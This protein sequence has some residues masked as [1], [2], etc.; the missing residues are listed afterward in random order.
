MPAITPVNPRIQVNGTEISHEAMNS[1]TEV[2]VE[3]EMRLPGRVTLRFR[4]PEGK[5]AKSS[6]FQ[7]GH[8]L[9]VKGANGSHTV[10]IIEA[11]ITGLGFEATAGSDAKDRFDGRRGTSNEFLVIAHDPS[12]RLTRNYTVKGNQQV[13]PGDIVQTLGSEAGLTVQQ[14]LTG[15][16][17]M[18]VMSQLHSDYDL[19]NAIADREGVDWWVENRTLHMGK[20]STT[21]TETLKLGE[22]LRSFSVKGSGLAPSK[23]SVRGYLSDQKQDVVKTSTLTDSTLWPKDVAVLSGLPTKKFGTATLVNAHATPTS[24]TES[25]TIANGI[26][27]RIAAGST[28]AHGE[29]WCN[30]GIAIGKSVKIDGA[31]PADGTY[32]VTKVEHHASRNGFFTRF[33]CGDRT[34]TSLVDSL[35]ARPAPS[36]PARHLGLVIGIVTNL[37]TGEHAGMLRVKLPGLDANLVSAWGR[38][39][40]PSAGPNGRGLVMLPE[41]GDE[42]LVGFEEGDMHRPVIL[43]GLYGPSADKSHA[44]PVTGNNITDRRYTSLNG[45]VVMIQDGKGDPN[46]MFKVTI[47]GD[48]GSIVLRMGGDKA[49]VTTPDDVPIEI[50]SGSQ[51]SIKMDG[52]GNIT[53]KGIKISIEAEAE[54][55][56]KAPKVGV[57]ADGELQLKSEGKADLQGAMVNVTAQG[58]L[59]AKGAIVQIN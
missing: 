55:S 19:L 52:K 14:S 59:A 40:A 56:I 18:T 34:P 4:D 12:F 51:S 25:E 32:H 43:G 9:T 15:G 16:S 39:V 37:G 3:T 50:S 13:T 46:N 28:R 38:F 8:T 49:E 44:W 17:P 30:P 21:S 53:I 2:R 36:L 27:D 20:A 35:A 26:R 47:K 5:L 1:L 31:G 58:P 24:S 22:D 41:I 45:H 11:D 57:A 7:I 29:T 48:K 6:T 33:W 42:V 10:P 23:V 54:L